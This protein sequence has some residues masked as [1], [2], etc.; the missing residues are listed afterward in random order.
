VP[1]RRDEGI[2]LARY[3]YRERDLIVILLTRSSGL[4]RVIARAARGVHSRMAGALEPLA[5][6]RFAIFESPRSELAR[7]QEA[8]LMISSYAIAGRP[9]AWAAAHVVAELAILLCPPGQPQPRVYRLVAHCL[10]VLAGSAEPAAVAAYAELWFLKL[11]GVFPEL[12]SCAECGAEL[13]A[14]ARMLDRA[15]S[16]VLCGGHP[17]PPGSLRLSPAAA[18]WLAEASA[19]PAGS[20]PPAPDDAV[21]LLRALLRD[22]TERDLASR[23]VLLEL[24]RDPKTS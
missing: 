8:E 10:D 5:R 11:A 22:F 20:V 23:G 7:L 21:E 15:E 4:V 17:A 9:R 13:G 12:T 18:S 16:R 1:V 3:P 2:V 19:R 24:Y 6:L 14:R